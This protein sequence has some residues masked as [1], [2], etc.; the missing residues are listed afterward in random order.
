MTDVESV[1]SLD[2]TKRDSLNVIVKTTEA[3]VLDCV[4][5]YEGR[6]SGKIMSLET[7]EAMITKLESRNPGN[8]STDYT[9]HGAEPLMAGL[10]FFRAAR[11]LQG[12][13]ERKGNRIDNGLQ[14]SGVLLDEEFADFFAQENIRVG[15]SLDGP[16]QYHDMQR[17]YL[18]GSSS[19]DHVMRGIQLM[20]ERGQNNGVIVVLTQWNLP[21]LN[22]IYEF[23]KKE[24]IPFKINPVIRCGNADNR[25][26]TIGLKPGQYARALINIF[27][28]AYRDDAGVFDPAEKLIASL[29]TR[30]DS[31]CSSLPSCQE[32]FIGVDRS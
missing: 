19:F 1:S 13:F 9:W 14:T 5:C 25:Y 21:H 6:K 22:E 12:H 11:E 27:E 28:M 8:T 4:Y 23:F 16:R 10:D 3:C 24:G 2:N 31:T 30:E 29:F 26:D 18:D 17:P 32:S 7:L 15:F 20:R